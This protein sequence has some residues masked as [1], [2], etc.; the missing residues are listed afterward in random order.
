MHNLS[1]TTD[2]SVIFICTEKKKKTQKEE[3]QPPSLSQLS[4]HRFIS[5]GH[6]GW[7]TQVHADITILNSLLSE[8]HLPL[9]VAALA[10]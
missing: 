1:L 4:L 8:I 6:H 9:N 2:F 7:S 10:G 5:I 3:E